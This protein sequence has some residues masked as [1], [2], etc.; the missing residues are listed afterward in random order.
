MD[1]C[2]PLVVAPVPAAGGG[3]P[4]LVQQLLQ[5]VDHNGG[6]IKKRPGT[7]EVA[8]VHPLRPMN[9]GYWRWRVLVS[10]SWLPRYAQEHIN[11]LE[12][13]SLLTA[14]RWRAR[15]ANRH[16]KKFLHLA[17]S[18]VAL[19]GINRARSP[20][21][22]LQGVI[23]KINVTVLAARLRLVLAHVASAGNPADAP[24]RRCLGAAARLRMQNG[25]TA[26]ARGVIKKD[27]AKKMHRRAGAHPAEAP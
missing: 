16:G 24:S 7:T 2:R 10:T 11:K 1:H 9:A 19:G 13:R 18:L 25:R 12:L 23:D 5:L 4:P 21:R 3:Q 6:L 15:R 8:H 22:D 14:V 26:R 17:D 20:S 27:K